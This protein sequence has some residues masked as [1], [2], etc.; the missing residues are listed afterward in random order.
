MKRKAKNIVMEVNED[1][2]W[3]CVSHSRDT[4]GY[5][6]IRH[7]GKLLKLS[8]F[9][10]E[11]QHGKIPAG[12]VVRH[13]CDNRACIN[14]DHLILGT[15]A[16]NVRDMMERGRSTHL[17]G[18]SNGA[19]KLTEKDVH[20]ILADTQHTQRELGKMFGVSQQQICRIKNRKL[21]KHITMEAN[22]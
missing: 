2:C 4:C 18:T 13:T 11:Q 6:L 10:Y 16:D 3:I 12:M 14:L 22:Q 5:P 17:C 19:S 8:R 1:G 21:W 15:Q 20:A 9:V 7:K